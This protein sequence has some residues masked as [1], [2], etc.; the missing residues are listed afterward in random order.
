M[1]GGRAPNSYHTQIFEFSIDD[2]DSS[3]S[4]VACGVHQGSTLEPVLF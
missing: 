1:K 3:I 2:P 4:L